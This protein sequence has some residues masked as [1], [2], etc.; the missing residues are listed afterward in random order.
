[1]LGSIGHM[2][3]TAPSLL[4]SW[5]GRE[6][7]GQNVWLACP[8]VPCSLSL[9]WFALL[10]PHSHAPTRGVCLR[11]MVVMVVWWGSA[12]PRPRVAI[13]SF[14]LS[15]GLGWA[16]AC[17]C[18]HP[19]WKWCS[20]VVLIKPKHLKGRTVL[21]VCCS[22]ISFVWVWGKG[23]SAHLLYLML[24]SI[25]QYYDAS[26]VIPVERYLQMFGLK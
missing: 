7:M 20:S 5:R 12:S 21:C 10:G 25:F 19:P 6:M 3:G 23:W 14:P 17:L 24:F 15:S 9:P 22:T 4:G 16:F 26:S 18:T 13:L 1:M 2:E 8:E 11:P